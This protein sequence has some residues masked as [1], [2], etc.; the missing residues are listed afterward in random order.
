MKITQYWRRLGISLGVWYITWRYFFHVRPGNQHTIT[1]VWSFAVKCLEIHDINHIRR[2]WSL[3]CSLVHVNLKVFT[4]HFLLSQYF[5]VSILLLHCF[6]NVMAHAQKPDFVFRRKGWVHLNWRGGSVRSTTGSRGVRISGS[7]AGYFMFRGSVKSAGYTL[8]SPV[9]PSLP[10]PLRHRVPS[11]FNST[12]TWATMRLF[13]AR[14]NHLILPVFIV[15]VTFGDQYKLS[16]RSLHNFLQPP[17]TT[18]PSAPIFPSRLYSLNF[19]LYRRGA[20]C[21]I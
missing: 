17:I 10:Q 3:T 1:G 7:N 9:S 19:T 2:A 20:D 21:F 15:L 6:W 18:H 12:L 4:S 16:S 5:V 13:T 8:N 11:H 14:P